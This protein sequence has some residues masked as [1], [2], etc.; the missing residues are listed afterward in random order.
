M[1]PQSKCSQTQFLKWSGGEVRRR[2]RLW[3]GGEEWT[4]PKPDVEER[5]LFLPH[6]V[7]AHLLRQSVGAER[8]EIVYE[9]E[10]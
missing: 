5:L 8:V 7:T 1:P 4:I 2:L 9:I 3:I 10:G 6:E